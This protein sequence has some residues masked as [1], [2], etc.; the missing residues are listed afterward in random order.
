MI[1]QC[2]IYKCCFAFT[3]VLIILV[4]EPV[5]PI[6]PNVGYLMENGVDQ[7]C[8]MESKA[9]ECLYVHLRVLSDALP[10]TN[11][12]LHLEKALNSSR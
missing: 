12:F 2:Y 1:L 3:D 10:S 8:R 7:Y 4:L 9:A 11:P 5:S 6:P